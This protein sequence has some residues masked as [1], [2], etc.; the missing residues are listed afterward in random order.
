[1]GLQAHL[2]FIP[3]VKGR[4]EELSKKAGNVVGRMP[5]LKKSQWLTK[6]T[7]EIQTSTRSLHATLACCRTIHRYFAA[8]CIK[9]HLVISDSATNGL[10]FLRS[11]L[12]FVC[13]ISN[14]CLRSEFSF[15]K[16]STLLRRYSISCIFSVTLS[17]LILF[18]CGWIRNIQI[19][20]TI[21][22]I[23]TIAVLCSS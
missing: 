16:S 7:M 6:Q 20:T 14:F 12:V 22:T 13:S 11:S 1:M 9:F 17:S 8:L 19:T 15:C 4:S 3:F 23:A 18:S 10:Q 2:Y 21:V 5:D